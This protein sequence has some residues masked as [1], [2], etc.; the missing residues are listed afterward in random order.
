[1]SFTG[2]WENGKD[3]GRKKGGI[4]RK[5]EAGEITFILKRVQLLPPSFNF[6]ISKFTNVIPSTIFYFLIFSEKHSCSTDNPVVLYESH[7]GR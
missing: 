3:R 6:L 2:H 7:I 5:R 4:K 1:M